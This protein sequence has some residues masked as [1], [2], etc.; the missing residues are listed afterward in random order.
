MKPKFFS[1]FSQK[2]SS[3]CQLALPSLNKKSKFREDKS[4]DVLKSEVKN[5]RSEKLFPP[6]LKQ[7]ANSGTSIVAVG[8]RLLSTQI[9]FKVKIK[10]LH[11]LK[12]CHF[13]VFFSCFLWNFHVKYIINKNPANWMFLTLPS[14][15]YRIFNHKPRIKRSSKLEQEW[16]IC[17]LRL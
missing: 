6:T 17:I 10:I 12:N 11:F 13:L 5:L 15:L 14:Y 7:C 2:T 16:W 3:V 4:D 8:P 9:C 1:I